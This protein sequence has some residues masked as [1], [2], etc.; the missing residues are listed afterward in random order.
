MPL[1][2][3]STDVIE[4]FGLVYLRVLGLLITM[5]VFSSAEIP[6]PL[7]AAL[8][9]A[10]AMIATIVLSGRPVTLPA[11]GGGYVLA[12]ISEF[13]LGLAAGYLLHW[14]S[15][16]VAIG[17]QMVGFQMGLAIVN[18][19]DPITGASISLTASFQMRVAVMVFLV[20]GLYREF[21]AA[22][23]TSFEL[24]PLGAA[25]W[26]ASYARE[27][28]ETVGLA[29]KASIGLAGT[30]IV[31]LLLAKLVLGIIARTVP[32]MNVFV[33]GFPLTIAVG[34]LAT[35]AVM[36]LFVE[37]VQ[38]DYAASLRRMLLFLQQTAP[39]P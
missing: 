22:I 18:V 26:K 17:A 20:S 39:Q 12:A 28:T 7:R 2:T 10:M 29:L 31:S 25:V 1:Y 30:P 8:A 6:R 32:Q 13:L 33:V 21:V 36:P 11:T 5:P 23:F 15:E 27:F 24:V 9:A 19:I 4:L 34:L 16:A 38:Q 37:W 35:A 3:L 14:V